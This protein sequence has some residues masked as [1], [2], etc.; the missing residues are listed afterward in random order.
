MNFHEQLLAL[1]MAIALGRKNQLEEALRALLK[2]L[3][4]SKGGVYRWEGDRWEL[5]FA[6]EKLYQ[7]ISAS[8]I[9]LK[10]PI[11]RGEPFGGRDG[12]W[13]LAKIPLDSSSPSHLLVVLLPQSDGETDETCLQIAAELLTSWLTLQ[14]GEKSLEH[15]ARSF[16]VATLGELASGIAHE[17]NNPLQVIIGNTEL[18]LDTEDLGERTKGKLLDILEAAEQIRKIAH[19]ITHFADA[20]R[21]EEKELLDLNKVVQE[22]TELVSY[23]LIREGISVEL[24]LS[25]VPPVWGRRGDLEEIVVQLVRNAGEAI[26]ESGKGGHVV[27]RT[28][29]RNQSVRLEVEDDGPGV[30]IELRERIFDPFVTTKAAKGGTGLGLAIVQNIVTAHSGR[31]WLEDSNFGGAKFVVELPSWQI[32]QHNPETSNEEGE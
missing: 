27:V 18:I 29:A 21:T 12:I 26:A 17:I 7:T 11:E 28:K 15:L 20:R 2:W 1:R 8:A 10:R 22:A 14:E 5:V 9:E 32:T 23:S 3:G 19:A 31:I 16:R 30:P 6:S 4:A 13:W 24:E 25:P